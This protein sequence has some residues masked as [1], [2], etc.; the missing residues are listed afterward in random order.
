MNMT[1]TERQ[2]HLLAEDR[3]L[4]KELGSAAP[5]Q[6]KVEE[7]KLELMNVVNKFAELDPTHFRVAV[8]TLRLTF[9]GV[10]FYCEIE[11]HYSEIMRIAL[12]P[13]N[14]AY[15]H[16]NFFRRRLAGQV[17]EEELDLLLEEKLVFLVDATG[18]PVLLSLLVLIFAAGGEDRLLRAH[19][20]Q[21]AL[22]R[23][24]ATAVRVGGGDGRLGGDVVV[25]GHATEL[26]GCN[27]FQLTDG[28]QCRQM[29]GSGFCEHRVAT[30]LIRAVRQVTIRVTTND[31]TVFPVNF[32]RLS[33][34]RQR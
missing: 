20:H 24:E 4:L 21:R 33:P 2:Q 13:N 1:D 6:P 14:Q 7:A 34:C 9:R 18:I 16:Y 26:R 32:Q 5:E 10:A 12:D 8:L 15:S 11:I 22:R 28:I 23:G 3:Q 29:V 17:P 25:I 31:F 27:F 19:P 30:G